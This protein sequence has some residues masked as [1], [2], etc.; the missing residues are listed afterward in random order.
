M[1]FG[2]PATGHVRRQICGHDMIV[3]DEK[4]F[5]GGSGFLNIEPSSSKRL[6]ITENEESIP[7][8]HHPNFENKLALIVS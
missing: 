8:K 2:R 3:S 5:N 1:N 7:S 4:F 6:R